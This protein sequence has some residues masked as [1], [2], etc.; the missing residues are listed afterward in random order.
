[1][2]T[3]CQ[4][5]FYLKVN[6]NGYDYVQP[7]C[8]RGLITLVM[9]SEPVLGPMILVFERFLLLT[10]FVNKDCPTSRIFSLNLKKEGR[11]GIVFLNVEEPQTS[12]G[13]C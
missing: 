7:L 10:S 4:L 3:A 11:Y 6:V 12:S 1:M 8:L 13:S 5:F 2:Q 9:E